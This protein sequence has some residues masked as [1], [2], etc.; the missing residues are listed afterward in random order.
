[1][2]PIANGSGFGKREFDRPNCMRAIYGESG[3]SNSDSVYE[4]RFTVDDMTG[5]DIAFAYERLFDAGAA[6]V[7][8]CPVYMK[9]GRPGIEFTCLSREGELE[10][11]TESIFKY[12]STLGFRES[13]V[14]R[15]IMNRTTDTVSTAYGPVRV[16]SSHYG[17]I[18][19]SKA[20]YEDV[21]KLA[22]ENS[23]TPDEIRKEIK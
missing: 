9:K 3:R 21:R 18:H 16:K 1:M 17:N 19:R 2:T 22:I 8:T 12:T 10:K 6:D 7:Y 15:R 23:T 11:L 13:F 14:T 5:E 20:E 4:L